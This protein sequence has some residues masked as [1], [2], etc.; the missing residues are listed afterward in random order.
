MALRADETLTTHRRDAVQTDNEPGTLRRSLRPDDPTVSVVVPTLNEARN[1]PFALARLPDCVTE[2]IIVDGHSTDDTTEIA[3]HLRADV[4][5]VKELRKGKGIALQR[6]FDEAT[7]DIVVMLDADGS[8]DPAE[9]RWF[10]DALVGGADFAKGSR[11]LPG[12]GSID[13]TFIRQLGNRALT[14]AVN[15][16][17][18]T[19]YT[20]LCYG[21]NAFWRDCLEFVPVDVTG[22][23]VETR[24]NM[25]VAVSGLAVV[26][27]PSHEFLRVHG[28]SN[29]HAIKDGLRVLKTIITSSREMRSG[30]R[31]VRSDAPIEPRINRTDHKNLFVL[32]GHAPDWVFDQTLHAAE[33]MTA[34]GRV[35]VSMTSDRKP[36]VHLP[37]SVGGSTLLGISPAGFPVWTGRLRTTLGLRR[38]I[39]STSIVMFDGARSLMMISAAL[40]G[41]LRR[42][43]VVLQ[44]LRVDP[45]T[46]SKATYSL[47]RTLATHEVP[48]AGPLP[49]SARC[50]AVADVGGDHE[51]AELLT[52]SVS[53]MARGVA[54]GWQLVLVSD[55]PE[56]DRIVAA[57]SRPDSI[58]VERGELGTALLARSDVAIVR[59]GVD[60][61]LKDSAGALGV[62]IVV[63]GHPTAPRVSRSFHGEWLARKDPSSVLVALECA[64]GLHAGDGPSG[65]TARSEA[66]KLVA[67]LR[68]TAR[69]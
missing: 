46:Q 68:R 55:D 53:S 50:I 29:L 38:R 58:G 59:H 56:V 49:S 20:D 19:R 3:G 21:Y 4:R 40:I 44:D 12:G 64:G 22:F 11:F 48:T 43:R 35:L 45:S 66:R 7:G 54:D 42:E 60:R 5:V 52:D 25:A 63:V 18:Q 2:V 51:F 13:L 1:L 34:D 69:R 15:L 67:E 24:L 47:L 30:R 57:G 31:S 62:H 32:A 8:A 36:V 27:V 10:V 37:G 33:Q 61:R 26:E 17:C 41:R 23:E 9:I 6:G 65:P 39:D 14:G 16:V 28:T